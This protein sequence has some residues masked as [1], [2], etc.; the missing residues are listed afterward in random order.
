M[1]AIRRDGHSEIVCPRTDLRVPGDHNVANALAAIAAAAQIGV[2]ASAMREVIR[3]F[4]GV[5]H[6][7]QLVGSP[8]GVHYYNDSI[9]T[10]PDRALAALR[11]ITGPVLLI[12][13]GHDKL[14]PWDELCAVAVARCRCVLLIG[15]AQDLISRQLTTALARNPSGG[16]QPS[17]VVGCGDLEHAIFEAQRRALPGDAVLLSPGCASYDQFR[18]FEERGNRFRQ[19]VEGLNANH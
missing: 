8:Y 1:L 6:R 12:L 7:L 10:S 9:A 14:L 11:A 5:P 16:L 19:L 17:A 18:N 4:A 3:S 13:G 2:P 15:E